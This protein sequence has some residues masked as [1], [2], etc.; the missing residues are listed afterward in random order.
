MIKRENTTIKI[1]KQ[2]SDDI[3]EGLSAPSKFL[4]S[5]YFYNEIGDDLFVQI[6]N[7]PEY[8]LSRA[9]LEIFADKTQELINSFDID[10]TTYFELIELGAGDGTKTKHLLQALIQQGYNFKYFPI[11]ISQNAL[12]QLE[13]NL[14]NEFG[15]LN[16][17]TKQ[18]DYFEVL[19]SFKTS[20]HKK[21]VLFLGS[22]IGNL[23]DDLSSKFLYE[24][25]SN[26]NT[27]D[28]LLLGTDLI[29]T[30]DIVL[31]AYDD[32]AGI[33]AR[34]NLNLLQRINTELGGNFDLSKFKHLAE[35]TT[36]EGIAKSYLVSLDNQF[37]FI[38]SI[39]K[40]FYFETGEKIHTEIS[41]KYNDEVVQSIIKNT[42]F[43]LE[44]KITD[45]KSYFADYILKRINRPGA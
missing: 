43:V 45:S 33:T 7:M 11:D 24:L 5:K 10:P 40:M 14:D 41:R 4:P 39:G 1:N 25:G 3:N 28:R 15:Q 12:D 20:S 18:G 16:F 37:V 19:S 22:N 38:E 8:Y 31:P 42:D 9:E 13:A 6:M 21:V 30:K 35:Y 36:A 27:D 23:T 34:F 44:A 29:K 17:S 26:L 2:F 32:D